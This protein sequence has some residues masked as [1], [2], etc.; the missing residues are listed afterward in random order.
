MSSFSMCATQAL[1]K[2][3]KAA[4]AAST[5]ARASVLS[6]APALSA[7]FKVRSA[8]GLSGTRRLAHANQSSSRRCAALIPPAFRQ[9]ARHTFY[10]YQPYRYKAENERRRDGAA[11]AGALSS[12]AKHKS[13]LRRTSSQGLVWHED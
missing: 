2:S 5:G 7:V 12:A 11:E 13:Q 4:A 9:L 6:S 10:L 8:W 3:Q 1:Q